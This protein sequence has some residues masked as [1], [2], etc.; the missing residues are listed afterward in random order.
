[1]ILSIV[2]ALGGTLK[3]LERSLSS[4]PEFESL[5]FRYG[6]IPAIGSDEFQ[7]IRQ[8]FNFV[9]EIQDFIDQLNELVSD[10]GFE[11]NFFGE[12]VENSNSLE[13]FSAVRESITLI[14]SIVKTDESD[15]QS[16]VSP[17]DQNSFWQE[18]SERILED[19]F[20]STLTAC[21]PKG[22]AFLHLFGVIEYK[23]EQPEG[24][25]RVTYLRT[26]IHWNK[27]VNLFSS[28]GEL[29]RDVYS[30]NKPGEPFRW[31]KLLHA[32]ERGFLVNQQLVRY[33]APR[34]SIVESYSDPD[35]AQT[36]NFDEL[37]LPLIYGTSAIEETFYNVGL[38]LMPIGR[39]NPNQ[40]PS[41][42]LITPI[43]EGELSNDF[44]LTPDISI[45]FDAALNADT[46]FGIKL[47]P[48]DVVFATDEGNTEIS[49]SVGLKGEPFSPW[50][51][52][53]SRN[54][55]RLEM[56]GFELDISVLGALDDPEVKISFRTIANVPS[57]DAPKTAGMKLVI[58]MDE[59]DNFLKANVSSNQLEALFDVDLE[60]SSKNGFSFNGDAELSL[61]LPLNQQFG[62]IEIR[63]FS[64]NI[65]T[66]SSTH[67]QNLVKFQTGLG[68]KGEFGPV[69]FYVEDIGFS[70]DLTAYS[71]EELS[72]L[73]T[74]ADTP[75]LGM[76]D[77]DL[78][79]A[80]PTAIGLSINTAG[81]TG[82]GSLKIDPPHYAGV[83]LLDVK[84]KFSIMAI[85]VL[86]TEL[87][88]GKPGFSMLFQIV[89]EFSPI[90]L[91]LGFA[92][93]G[94]GGMV[95]INRK[96]H[97]KN[98]RQA[99][100][101]HEF[102]LFPTE[103]PDFFTIIDTYQAVLPAM[104]GHHIFG[105][106]VKIH[107]GG[108]IK[109]VEFEVGVFLQLGGSTQ[110]LIV[111][112]AWSVLPDNNTKILV[113][114]FDVFGII[115]FADG[116][117][118]IEATLSPGS[119][120]MGYDL[121]GPMALKADWQGSDKTFVMSVGGFHPRFKQ[122]PVGFPTL[123]RLQILAKKSGA[124]ITLQLYFAITTNSLQFGALLDISAKKS[125]FKI[126]GGGGFDALII[127][128]PFSFNVLI[129]FWVE[130]SK[131]WFSV[132]LDLELELSGPNP[133]RAKGYVKFSYGFGSKKVRF[134]KKFGEEKTQQLPNASPVDALLTELSNAEH[135][136]FELPSWA[137]AGVIYREGAESMA[138]PL[139]D[140]IISQE[141]VPLKVTIDKFGGTRLQATE[142]RLDI[143]ADV[144]ADIV[145]EVETLFAP[146][147]FIAMSDDQKLSS[148]AFTSYKSG[149]RLKSSYVIPQ[150]SET[151]ALVFE[152][153]LR[154]SR[155]YLPVATNDPTNDYRADFICF[156]VPDF[157]EEV[158]RVA[159]WSLAGAGLIHTH[160]NDNVFEAEVETGAIGFD[161][162][163]ITIFDNTATHLEGLDAY[164]ST[165]SVEEDITVTF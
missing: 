81:V 68:V 14:E 126:A 60:W 114:N 76:L 86:T 27:F 122:I 153:V 129:Y 11:D 162:S 39:G 74:D 80:P 111:G 103:E 46:A 104:K 42:I 63:F 127:F 119:K 88:D 52:I 84:D 99:I 53:G 56:N 29:F 142:R 85:G 107:W 158:S 20:V 91:G 17:F 49:T 67:S 121:D 87:P 160:T 35:Y 96:L 19:V 155:L 31:Q 100:Q 164:S 106:I 94:V 4:L 62:P 6:W 90:Q 152:T 113:L 124:D 7:P 95:G 66:E 102:D 78:N 70:M 59:A 79:F 61:N 161:D 24:E 165:F 34:Q 131:S 54:S 92:L 120:F 36:N 144:A 71:H 109:L 3:S 115:D 151:R 55:H 156:W 12:G 146:A 13:L 22:F 136:K 145:E 157:G 159:N 41:G 147:Q 97:E 132:G 9:D 64:F 141:A 1:M 112:R 135:L 38:G 82:G 15:I 16:L 133:L 51:L 108:T 148:P 125:G 73:P 69:D 40:P 28:P 77:F 23:E 75:L 83:L 123:R 50:I 10:E 32:I 93:T 65:A 150:T 5:L 110:V 118:E 8:A 134:N 30:W 44:F 2:E 21:S 43:L 58:Q 138:D 143:E 116:R 105:P 101:N 37:T 45:N 48:D 26:F 128:N 154:E 139:A 117:L 149:L 140:I 47:F 163:E 137:R 33:S 18:I 89:A 25:F 98:M 72:N 130:V 57:A